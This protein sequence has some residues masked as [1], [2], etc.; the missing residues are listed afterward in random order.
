MNHIYILRTVEYL[1]NCFKGILYLE[2]LERTM[3][4]IEQEL[5][6]S[7]QMPMQWTYCISTMAIWRLFHLIG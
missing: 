3:F 5:P 7:T 2:N 4:G 1:V 6:T